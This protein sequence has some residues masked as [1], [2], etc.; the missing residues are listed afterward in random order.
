[1]TLD[2]VRL[3]PADGPPLAAGGFSRWLSRMSRALSSDGASDVPCGDCTACCEGSYFIHVTPDDA[4]AR[5]RIPAAVLFPAPGAGPGHRVMG[6]DER[7][8]CPML[9]GGRCTIYADRP[10]TC[11]TYD[12][13]IFA[14]TGLA[15]PGPAKAAIMARAAR[16]HFDYADE[17]DRQ[18]HQA[19]RTAAWSVVASADTLAD[20]LPRNA[21][22]L[23]MLLVRHHTLLLAA[24]FGRD[25]DESM[26]RLRR[27]LSAH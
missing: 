7:G 23:A 2:V 25:G 15:E 11:R 6:Y 3:A 5:R 9:S 24:D 4:G 26:A 21:T 1:M 22:Q 17:S 13:R 12:C 18:R 10:R 27:A 20:V 16:W 19:L 8:R 14:A